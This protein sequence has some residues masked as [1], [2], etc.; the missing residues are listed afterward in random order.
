MS[1][2]VAASSWDRR[3]GSIAGI[4]VHL[5]PWV[6]LL[7]VYVVSREPDLTRA[8]VSIVALLL[9]VFVHELGHAWEAKRQRLSP[10]I[11][12][13]GMGGY[14]SHQQ[15]YTADGDFRVTAA[16]PAAGFALALVAFVLS[17]LLTTT[18]VLDLFLLELWVLGA[19]WTVVNLLP[20]Q[21]LDGGSMAL[22][23]ARRFPSFKRADYW[24][25]VVGVQLALLLAVAGG[26]LG[27]S[28]FSILGLVF[29]Y[30]NASRL[31]WVPA[32][33]VVL[34][35][36]LGDGPRGH[37]DGLVG[38]LLL[39]FALLAVRGLTSVAVPA[40]TV[41]GLAWPELHVWQGV[42]QQLAL[43]GPVMFDVFVAL[44]SGQ[45]FWSVGKGGGVGRLLLLV[46]FCSVITLPVAAVLA[47]SGAV[48]TGSAVAGTALAVLLLD[49]MLGARPA[50]GRG[51][52]WEWALPV[53]VLWVAL[54]AFRLLQPSPQRVFIDM[55]AAAGGFLFP[56]ALLQRRRLLTWWKLR[57]P[58]PVEF[59]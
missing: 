42:T 36:G 46:L 26:V 33:P 23:L 52:A 11:T 25:G 10:S 19:F 38:G 53:I 47:T 17:R 20:I 43:D 32:I 12:L 22:N 29:A 2:P 9:S 28:L 49:L 40:G 37:V 18:P 15:A 39:G 13:H 30:E 16:G 27:Q 7:V 8:L 56:L 4:P 58:P 51:L 35:G 21:P 5:S 6:L 14:C 55:T 41:V 44:V 34:A 48:G 1:V 50:R 31:K 45:L 54:V 59:H 3:V 57:D 24:M